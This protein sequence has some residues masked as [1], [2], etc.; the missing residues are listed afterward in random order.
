MSLTGLILLGLGAC[1]L[2]TWVTLLLK[3][4]QF[5]RARRAYRRYG[6]GDAIRL[7][8]GGPGLYETVSGHRL[9]GGLAQSIPI[10]G[11]PVSSGHS[12]RKKSHLWLIERTL[13]QQVE[14]ELRRMEQGLTLLASIGSLSPFVGLF[15]TVLGIM[16]AL[17]SLGH[18]VQAD[19]GQVAGPIGHALLATAIGIA[20]AVPAVLAYNGCLRWIRLYHNDLQGIVNER[21][22]RYYQQNQDP[23][24]DR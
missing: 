12:S 14:Q 10:P 20:S 22:I 16:D 8:P 7:P 5:A 13:D 1:A 11:N 15:G 18:G 6:Q 17:G 21:L 2:L 3:V 24:V 19:L 9:T 4:L 23:K